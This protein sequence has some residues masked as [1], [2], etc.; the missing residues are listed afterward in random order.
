MC[1]RYEL[2]D[3]REDIKRRLRLEDAT[4]LEKNG[5]VRPTNGVPVN[6]LYADDRH[7]YVLMRWGLVPH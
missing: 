7:E 2:N 6:R 3:S 1:G 5:D 4:E